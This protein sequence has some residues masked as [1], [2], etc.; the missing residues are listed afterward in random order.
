MDNETVM[1]ISGCITTFITCWIL[2]IYDIKRSYTTIKERKEKFLNDIWCAFFLFVICSMFSWITM[3]V[4][5]TVLLG[6]SINKFLKYVINN[7]NFGK[8]LIYK[9]FS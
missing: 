4:I 9:I 5:M 2:Y 8:I 7:T 1:Y 6:I 3:G